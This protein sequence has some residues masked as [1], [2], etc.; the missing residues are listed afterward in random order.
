MGE[1]LK[2]WVNMT[3][4]LILD[5][6]AVDENY[7]TDTIKTSNTSDDAHLQDETV[8]N[9]EQTDIENRSIYD[10][11]IASA[12]QLLILGISHETEGRN[13]EAFKSYEQAVQIADETDRNDIKSKSYQHLGNLF[14][15]TF[16]Y[17]KAIEYYLK[18]RE[19]SPDLE[20]NEIEVEA[21]Q[22]L[23]YNH[24]QAGQYQESREY[25][26]E[27]VKLASQL[28]D[29]KRKINAYLGLGSAFNSTGEFESSRKYFLKALTVAEQ[30]HDKILQKEAY[31]NLGA[32]YYENRKFDAAVKSYFKI[33]EISHDLGERKEEANACLML[34]DTF[35]ELKQHE[36]AIESYQETL[37]ISEE[38]EDKEMQIVAI[39]RL[40]TLYLVCCKDCDYENA[41]EWYEKAFNILGSQP[42]DHL[43]HVKAL[44]GLGD[45]ELEDKEMQA[46]AIQRLGT[47]YLTL[48]SVCCKDGDYEKAIT[49]YENALNISGKEPND[50]RLLHEKA[51]TG[52]GTILFRLGDTEKAMESIQKAQK[53]VKDT[54]TGK[55]IINCF[56]LSLF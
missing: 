10:D 16:E 40:G 33:K 13:E 8:H 1:I 20:G 11:R 28:G 30:L 46:V 51:L 29:K 42:N 49:W 26:N 6:D 14:T 2:E 45:E 53:F 12:E 7:D 24:I 37:N 50:H 32:V 31:R 41:I 38:L 44:T 52:L 21:Y 54:R 56:I 4:F 19:I 39:Q 23:A 5:L 3:A 25:Y 27:V 9:V 34:G 15:G 55:L 43:L 22:W 48:A 36:E 17:K 47:L 18:A 35:Q